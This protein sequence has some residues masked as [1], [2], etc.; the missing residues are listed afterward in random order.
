MTAP[1]ALALTPDHLAAVRRVGRACIS[2]AAVAAGLS[3]AANALASDGTP[4]GIT[5]GLISPAAFV[6]AAHI[7]MGVS[8]LPAIRAVAVLRWLMTG[9]LILIGGAAAVVSFGHITSVVAAH[10]ESELA[11]ILIAGTI[12]ATAVMGLIG[13]RV[14]SLYARAHDA[15]VRAAAAAEAREAEE[16]RLQIDADARATA[17]R[18]AR[19]EAARARQAKRAKTRAKVDP[20][21]LADVM[22]AEPDL[23]Q[24]ELA[25]RF[26]VSIS[27]IRRM[28]RTAT[29]STQS[30]NGTTPALPPA[31]EVAA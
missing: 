25:D 2:A 21:E 7:G 5:I 1:A 19:A 22:A 28:T 26:G 6:L 18:E 23:T 29:G 4:V 17:D 20:A 27:T 16:R 12:D 3:M 30:T 31:S 11:T 10:G 24:A 9:L 8:P 13:H 14:T 15:G